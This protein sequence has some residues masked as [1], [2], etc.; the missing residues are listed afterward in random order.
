MVPELTIV[1]THLQF[2]VVT[3]TD[4]SPS[5]FIHLAAEVDARPVFFPNSLT[6]KR[7]LAQ[8]KDLC[9]QL[10]VVSGVVDA[11]LFEAILI[12]PG[13]GEFIQK[14]EGKVHIAR[15]DI[16]VLIE[17]QNSDIAQSLRDNLVY[18]ELTRRISNVASFTHEI[19]ATNARRIAPVNYS[20]G[21]VFLFN[22]FFADRVDQNIAV[23]DYTAG[24]F[25]AETGL[26]NSVLLL[27]TDPAQSKYTLINHCRFDNLGQVL[28]SIIFKKTFH[29]FVLAN[30]AA[31]NVGPMP[32]LY[33]LA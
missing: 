8:C 6:K 12:P 19:L 23:W 22:Y 9:K 26:D 4:T 20:N 14:R 29:S 17:C 11:R 3:L 21:G 1:N 2:P 18:K 25:Q 7:V 24:W 33:R 10:Q 27:P 15:F 16:A 31:N 32:I 5:V 13:K 30:F 28:P